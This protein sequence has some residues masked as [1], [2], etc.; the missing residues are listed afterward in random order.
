MQRIIGL[1]LQVIQLNLLAPRPAPAE[2]TRVDGDQRRARQAADA[3]LT[4]APV[5][6]ALTVSSVPGLSLQVPLVVRMLTELIRS[7]VV[8]DGGQRLGSPRPG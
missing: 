1:G 4:S 6:W 3:D 2:G 8:A 5:G 7:A